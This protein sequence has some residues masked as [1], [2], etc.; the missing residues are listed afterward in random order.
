MLPCYDSNIII[1]SADPAHDTLRRLLA[2]SPG[3]VSAVSVVE[4][5]GYPEL[6][7][8]KRQYFED[9]FRL[10][11][12][13]PITAAVI[14]R[15]VALRQQKRMKLGDALIAATVLEAGLPVLVT[16]NTKDFVHITGLQLENPLSD[17]A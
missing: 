1:Y 13:L 9:V 4:T 5:L 16:R 17:E 8:D 3:F 2:E 12:I 14:N 11:R 15:A 6:P 10:Q 7:A